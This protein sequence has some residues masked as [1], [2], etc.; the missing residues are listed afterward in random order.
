MIRRKKKRFAHEAL[1][2]L[3][4]VLQRKQGRVKLCQIRTYNLPSPYSSVAMA[5]VMVTMTA[6]S[7]VSSWLKGSDLLD[8]CEGEYGGGF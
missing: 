7:P 4:Y 3:P 5:A 8:V 6:D 1:Q 2:S